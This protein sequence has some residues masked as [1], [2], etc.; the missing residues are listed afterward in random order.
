MR[1]VTKVYQD[2]A[3]K[4]FVFEHNDDNTTRSFECTKNR[5]RRMITVSK[6]SDVRVCGD[7]NFSWLESK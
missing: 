1:K 4:R 6:S 3:T 2:K 5:I 7:I